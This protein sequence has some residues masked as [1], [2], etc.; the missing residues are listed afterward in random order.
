MG[1][2]P[3]LVVS[4]V[5]GAETRSNYEIRENRERIMKGSCL[6][7]QGFECVVVPQGGWAVAG[8]ESL[9]AESLGTGATKPL[10]DKIIFLWGSEWCEAQVGRDRRRESRC[11]NV[12]H[13]S[14]PRA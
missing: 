11:D 1:F 13:A 9:T 5:S 6:Y 7:A 2:A 12:A 4:F 10:D 14:A 8:A 3:H